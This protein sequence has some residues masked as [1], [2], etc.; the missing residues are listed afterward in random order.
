MVTDNVDNAIDDV[1]YNTGAAI[2]QARA[3]KKYAVNSIWKCLFLLIPG[4][5]ANFCVLPL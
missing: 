1:F 2:C 5:L 4:E 3:Q